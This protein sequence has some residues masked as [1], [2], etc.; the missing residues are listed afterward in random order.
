[1]NKLMSVLLSCLITII[2]VFVLQK[3]NNFNLCSFS[4][5]ICVGGAASLFGILI[6]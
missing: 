3:I 5:G 6:K 1:M 4:M 2:V